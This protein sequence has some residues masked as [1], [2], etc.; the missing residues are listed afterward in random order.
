MKVLDAIQTMIVNGY[1]INTIDNKI[2]LKMLKTASK[3]EQI[4][5]CWNYIRVH[6]EESLEVLDSQIKEIEISI[7]IINV[8]QIETIVSQERGFL[9]ILAIDF[10]KS[11]RVVVVTILL[12]KEIVEKIDIPRLFWDN[13]FM[14]EQTRIYKE[15]LKIS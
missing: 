12:E 14:D 8:E 5:D 2:S 11:S 4:K 15:K 7:D 10:L 3:N 6:R 9:K 1:R 13:P